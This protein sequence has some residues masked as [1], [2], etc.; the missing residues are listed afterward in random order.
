[1]KTINFRVLI[2]YIA[3]VLFVLVAGTSTSAHAAT[4]SSPTAQGLVNLAVEGGELSFA[5]GTPSSPVSTLLNNSMQN[6]SFTVPV[7]VTDATGSGGGWTLQL[8]TNSEAASQSASAPFIAGMLD[9]CATNS[10]CTL[11]VNTISYSNPIFLGTD[12]TPVFTSTQGTGMGMIL[13]NVNVAVVLPA[14]VSIDD[15]SGNLAFAL[16]SAQA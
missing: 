9:R 12:T 11:P 6:V 4:V 15:Y 3:F 10:T 8:A 2:I 7:M 1:M 5:V 14:N 13:L 16:S